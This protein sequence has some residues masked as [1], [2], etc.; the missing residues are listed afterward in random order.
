MQAYIES[1]IDPS[2]TTIQQPKLLDGR[3]PKSA[4]LRL[5]RVGEIKCFS[6]GTVTTIVLA[7]NVLNAADHRYLS[8]ST[9]LPGQPNHLDTAANRALIEKIRLVGASIRLTLVNGS[10]EQDGFFEAARIPYKASDFEINGGPDPTPYYMKAY[11]LI[12]SGG[13]DISN[14]PTYMQGKLRDIHRYLFKLNSVD[15][16]HDFMTLAEPPTV[17]TTM[18]KAWDVIVIKITGRVDATTPSILLAESHYLHEVIYK[19]DTQLARLMGKNQRLSMFENILSKT[20]FQ[21][22]AVMVY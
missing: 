21:K 14:E 19:R 20:D 6:D 7:P 18:D 5:R 13:I 10:T 8:G 4:G 2:S 1:L 15:P 9:F 16:D 3:A 17:A 11:P 22:P 12:P